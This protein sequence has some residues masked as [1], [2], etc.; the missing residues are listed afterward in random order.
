M[1]TSQKGSTLSDTGPISEKRLAYFRRRLQNRF[2]AVILKAFAQQEEENGLNQKEL[3]RR[4]RRKPEVVNRWLSAAANWE[5]DTI[6]DLLLG[7]EVDFDDPTFTPIKELVRQSKGKSRNGQRNG[8]S[9][10]E[11]IRSPRKIEG[12]RASIST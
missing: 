6:S 4:I 2:H 9:R 1:T 10:P 11:R 7:M 8:R 5:L 12:I 3:A